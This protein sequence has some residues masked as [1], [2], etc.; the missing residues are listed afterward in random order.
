MLRRFLFGLALLIASATGISAAPLAPFYDRVAVSSST[1]GTGT[2]TLGAAY[3]ILYQT[4]AGASVPSGSVVRYVIVDG[5]IGWE[6]GYGTYTSSGTTL[7]R[8]P[9]EGTNGTSPLS[10]DGSEVVYL[11]PLSYDLNQLGALPVEPPQGRLTLTSNTPVMTADATAQSTIYYAAYQGDRLPWYDGQGWTSVEFSSELS[12]TLDAT[13]TASGNL[14][15]LFGY[16]N[17][18]TPVMCYGPAW[19]N[20]TTRSTAIAQLNGLWVNSSSMTCRNSSSTTYTVGADKGTYLGTF[21]AT[22]AGQTGVSCKPAAAANGANNFIGLWNAYRRVPVSCVDVQSTQSYVNATQT[23][24]PAGPSGA[25]VGFRVT[26]VDGL[27]QSPA[28]CD[29]TSNAE[30][31]ATSRFP[32]VGCDQNSTTATPVVIG[33]AASAAS[34]GGQL[35]A[36]ENFA[37]VMGLNYYQAMQSGTNVTGS[38]VT[39]NFA[40]GSYESLLVT[41]TW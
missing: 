3:G 12:V 36:R 32:F 19:T 31:T 23:W 21:Y 6:A 22:A 41:T 38:T 35:T 11:T 27:G 14:Y 15:D 24:G 5:S 8:T 1:T 10:L 17:S 33:S 20:S 30:T 4:P 25:Y 37:P 16:V 34:S 18:G 28:Y 2:L 26:F 40:T 39:W 29:Y 7:T 13:N 9:Q